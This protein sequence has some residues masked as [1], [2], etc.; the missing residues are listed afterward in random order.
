MSERT[1]LH[2]LTDLGQAVWLDYIRRSFIES[3]DLQRLIDQGLRG[4]TSNP[5]IFRQAIAGSTDYDDALHRL[6][7]A[8]RSRDEIY[9]S[10][11]MDDIRRAA[12]LLRP[13][14]KDSKGGDGFVSLEVSPAL[15]E[16]TQATITEAR[17]LYGAVDRPNVMIKVPATAEGIP[18][19]ETLIG[20]GININVTLMFSLG[21]YDDVAE[22]YIRGL[23]RLAE[24]EI[25]LS[26]VNSVAS[27]FVSR[28]DSA[29]DR[30]LEE[31]GEE[32]LQGQIAVANA[33]LAYARFQEK[34][35]GPRWD[36]L[37]GQGARPQRVLWASTS[38]K[39]PQY[40]D[41][42]YV[43]NLIGPHT[44]N[45]LPPETLRAFLDHGAVA[46]TVDSNLADAHQKVDRL[47]ELG[48][49]LDSVTDRLLEEGVASFANSFETL[50][51]S[52]ADKRDQI[53]S[54]WQHRS[55]NLG[56]YSSP[57]DQALGEMTEAKVVERIWEHDHTLWKPDPAEIR[58]RLGW[59]NTVEVMADNLHRLEALTEA[60]REDG[61]THALLLGMGGSSLAPYVIRRTFGAADGY[62]NLEILDTT[63]PAAIRAAADSLDPHRAL[64]IVASKS[65]T[66]VEALSLFR[67]F[68]N[69][70]AEAVGSAEAGAHFVAITDPGS[71]LI[72]IAKQ[73]RFRAIFLNDP[74]IG[75]RYS[76]LSYFGL[77]PA[78]LIGVPVS[79]L[80]DRAQNVASAC[81]S[82]VE[83]RDNP[84]AWLGAVIGE[85]AKIGR[86]KL[87]V[88][89]SASIASLGDWIEQLIAESTGKEGRGILPVV[90]EPLGP[91]EVYGED[92]I[93]V[94]LQM[95]GDGDPAT[96]LEAL[97]GAGHP[98]VRLQLHDRYD[99]G[100][101]FFQ[102]E[103]ATAVA[104]H[105]IGI[106]PFDQPNVEAAK[107]LA[108]K[109]VVEYQEEGSLPEEAPALSGQGVEVYGEVEAGNPTEALTKFLEPPSPGRY[110][111]LQA[112]LT[113]TDE[114]TTELQRLR[115]RIRDRTRLATTMGFGPRYLHSTGQLHKGDAGK[116]LFVQFTAEDPE[117]LPIPDQAGSSSSSMGFGVLKA[118]QAMGDRR[119]LLGGGRQVL[120]LHLGA[121]PIAGLIRLTKGLS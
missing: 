87:T 118:A 98:V 65:G 30:A 97:E 21:Q 18:A 1:K 91:P 55:A 48:I 33:K 13:V 54:G 46:Q 78:H 9:D 35:A 115:L 67:H 64:L 52:I 69:W 38:T 73:H 86:D 15:A 104:G 57:V 37:V 71:P 26:G 22:A 77:V 119:A 82:C 41:T 63:D 105:R 29:V 17:R 108:R 7:D 2:E 12:D 92:R 103:M 88:S 66:T 10:L 6:V 49:D 94:R 8:G 31:I 61:Y 34:F 16:D 11:V 93:F 74:A 95:D 14:H 20:E 27:F 45:T 83:A 89:A 4:I 109:M 5:T 43:D 36:K 101:Q 90:A 106:N 99:L 44:V 24:A 72:G 113:P 23:E 96:A 80:L 58:N 32:A 62:L 114:I 111:A 81:E 85:L 59:L 60:V 25:E 75:G 117:D 70:T 120:R 84:G 47:S 112:Y 39:N 116:G 53:L 51:D 3:G 40:P 102:W 76:A 68:F 121:D 42:L 56:P 28:V 19:I 110:V 107:T 100:G 79:E 50:I